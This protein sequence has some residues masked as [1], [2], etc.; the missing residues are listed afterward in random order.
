MKDFE[1]IKKYINSVLQEIDCESADDYDRAM[2]LNAL[3]AA[4]KA[5]YN[6][7][8]EEYIRRGLDKVVTE[9]NISVSEN[10]FINYMYGN[11]CYSAGM[12]DVAVNIARQTISQPRTEAGYFISQDGRECLCTAFTALSFYMNYETRNGGK[13]HYNDIIA[14]FN[15]LHN[16]LFPQVK[17]AALAG[18]KDAFK[19]LSL[20][21]AG[22]IDTMEVMD[23]ALY[24]IFA[25]LRDIYK[26][27][28][29]ILK[30]TV[31][32]KSEELKLIYSYAIL[33]GCRMRVIQTEKY[34][35][36]AESIFEQATKTKVA[37]KDKVYETAAY[38]FAYSEYIR[39]R[40][41]QDY[42]RN[43]G[44]VLWN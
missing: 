20:Y 29:Q 17:K 11:V 41:Y 6:G 36:L 2:L 13:E 30:S 32:G 26:E 42:G 10:S 27:T 37:A 24:E 14:Q 25:R 44:G 19:A 5:M 35:G 33:K 23:Q 8:Y 15:A 3:A 28:V 16:N 12:A 43:H 7:E 31:A 21:A 39:N 1:K 9:E 34:A 40:E 4:D 38:I 22:T 18:D